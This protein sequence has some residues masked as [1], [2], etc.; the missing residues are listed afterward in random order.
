MVGI[1]NLHH[2]PMS[3]TTETGG[4]DVEVL[5][6]SEDNVRIIGEVFAG[7]PTAY[8]HRTD[9]ISVNPGMPDDSVGV[10]R[11]GPLDDVRDTD[12]S[13]TKNR[14]DGETCRTW[15]RTASG[16]GGR[17]EL[18]PTGI[19]R[20]QLIVTSTGND[21]S[22]VNETLHRLLGKRARADEEQGYQGCF[23]GQKNKPIAVRNAS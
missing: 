5:A 13:D 15:I 3:S 6:G 23:H 11:V 2:R 21:W 16:S 7:V 20:H 9:V 18:I 8:K 1:P 19:E 10:V 12:R 14:I 17:G 22:D 4:V